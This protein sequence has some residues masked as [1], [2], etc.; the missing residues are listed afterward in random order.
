MDMM[1]FNSQGTC[2]Y[3]NG[4]A[5]FLDARG[6]WRLA[7]AFPFFF[8]WFAIGFLRDPEARYERRVPR[9]S[10]PFPHGPDNW[11]AVT[12]SSGNSIMFTNTRDNYQV[13]SIGNAVS[14]AQ[15]CFIDSLLFLHIV[16]GSKNSFQYWLKLGIK[17]TMN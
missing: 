10:Y 3:S 1:Q 14:R 6:T 5:A 7:D 8:I 17:Q 9:I 11:S 2:L 4:Q 16:N 13:I 15:V 12:L